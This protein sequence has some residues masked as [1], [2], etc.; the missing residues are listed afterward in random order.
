MP[1]SLPSPPGAVLSGYPLLGGYPV[2]PMP[3]PLDG[4]VLLAVEDSRF[5]A[6]TLRILSR[7]A[8]A[9]L[10][11][12]EDLQAA[13]SHLSAYEPDII[14][15]DLGLPDGRGEDLIARL[16]GR[17]GARA[18]V[19]A[20][21]SGDLDR[22]QKAMAAGA[23]AFFEKPFTALTQMVQSLQDLLAARGRATLSY[24]NGSAFPVVDDVLQTVMDELALRDDLRRIEAA[25]DDPQRDLAEWLVDFLNGI[26]RQSKDPGL[27]QASGDL[28]GAAG[29]DR[30]FVKI[31]DLVRARI[32]AAEQRRAFAR[33]PLGRA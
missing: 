21:M 4:V 13:D 10:R 31:I 14:L 30:Q 24:R 23:D 12:A 2:T 16:R 26:A 25:L 22:A 11:R 3:L 32:A 8:G 20:A 5:A 6:E 18:P 28:R 9:R 1:I 29:S 17:W 19:L 33:R 7:R 27:V 15:V